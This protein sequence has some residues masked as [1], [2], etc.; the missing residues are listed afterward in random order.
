[1]VT[2][3]SPSSIGRTGGGGSKKR[4]LRKRN[5]YVVG[6]DADESVPIPYV[7]NGQQESPRVG[8]RVTQ[9]GGNAN[10]ASVIAQGKP[11]LPGF[12]RK[13]E[14]I[15][16]A[17]DDLPVEVP[18]LS[19]PELLEGRLSKGGLPRK[20]KESYR[21]RLPGV[22]VRRSLYPNL[23]RGIAPDSQGTQ[24][25]ASPGEENQHDRKC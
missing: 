12:P 5:R 3:R 14:Q 7:A 17:L 8:L 24:L 18:R 25:R 16:L 13:Q 9:I 22:H 20:L 6:P 11:Y 15:R 21:G 23:R 19:P 4:R 2:P 10:E 1:M